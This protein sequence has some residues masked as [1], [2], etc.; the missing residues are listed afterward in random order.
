[1]ILI[2]YV[3]GSNIPALGRYFSISHSLGSFTSKSRCNLAWI[4]ICIRAGYSFSCTHGRDTCSCVSPV[5][6][7]PRHT[8]AHPSFRVPD[9]VTAGILLLA[10]MLREENTCMKHTVFVDMDNQKE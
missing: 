6:L 2:L 10:Y 3:A 4:T 5:C 7:I 8:Q 1:M 9:Q